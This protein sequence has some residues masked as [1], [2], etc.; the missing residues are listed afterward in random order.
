MLQAVAA[1][2]GSVVAFA[3]SA[4]QWIAD[5]IAALAGWANQQLTSLAQMLQ[6]A[7][8]TLLGFVNNFLEFLGKVGTV[9]LDVW[10]LPLFLAEKVW[11]WVPAC[12]RDPIV[13]FVIPIIL[14]QIELFEELVRDNAAWQKTKAEVTKL[15]RQVFVDHDLMGALKGT[16]NLILRTFNIPPDLA[17]TV[18]Q[19]A[20][21]AWDIVVKKPL[22]FIKNTVRALGHGF[23]LLWANITDHLEYGIKGWLLGSIA[24]KDIQFP[25]DWT[26]PRE[27]FGFV[28]DV[29]GLNVSHIFEL[30]KTRINPTLVTKAQTW[31]TRFQGAWNWITSMIDTSKSPAENTKGVM[32]KA[33]DFGT[34]ILTGVVEWIAGKV[35]QELAI[36]AAAAAASGGLSEVVDIA[37][38]IYKAMLS[39]KRW[40]RQILEMANETLDDIAAI[41]SGAVEKAGGKFKD[42][43]HKGMPV[44]IGF[45]ADQVGLGGV[46]PAISGII[47]KLRAKV[48]EAVLWLIDKMK[49]G[50]EAL[51]NAVS[52]GAAKPDER[53]EAQKQADLDK[54]VAEATTLL[55]K[56]RTVPCTGQKETARNQV[57][58]QYDTFLSW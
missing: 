34:S 23:K 22:E 32:N 24:D 30:L 44:V 13:D 41:A 14:R 9:I 38:R 49:A 55:G 15:I 50:I 46:G 45:L 28:M 17:V 40:A 43:M 19:K 31:L 3:A 58:I 5:Q 12:I 27:V 57:Q 21:A 18:A 11:N 47:D 42:I 1:A 2:S 16:F 54:G 4:V 36:L 26:E 52:G 8:G 7:L 25:K 53:T 29:L 10:G 39:A 33:K 37:R 35:A 20:L 51:I 56:Q 48:D 6:S